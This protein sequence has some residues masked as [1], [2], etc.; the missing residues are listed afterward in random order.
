MMISNSK[1]SIQIEAKVMGLL[2]GQYL[3]IM[4]KVNL[5]NGSTVRQ[6]LK[7]L[8]DGGHIDKTVFGAVKRLKPPISVLINGENI[9]EG[10]HKTELHDGDTVSIFTP[11]AG[12]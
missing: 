1:Q 5:P 4:V 11:I 6:L 2:G 9:G 10:A 8:L 12:G 3:S 7:N